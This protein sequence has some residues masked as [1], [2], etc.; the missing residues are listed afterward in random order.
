[1]HPNVK[2][3]GDDQM[4]LYL[5]LKGWHWKDIPGEGNS[6]DFGR[7]EE[8]GVCDHVNRYC[9]AAVSV[10]ESNSAQVSCIYVVIIIYYTSV[11]VYY[12]KKRVDFFH[13]F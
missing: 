3:I 10:S 9:R 4:I 5:F 2:Y 1:M 7:Q 8:D 6:V 13:N 12:H 11:N